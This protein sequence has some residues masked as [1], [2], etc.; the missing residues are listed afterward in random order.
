MAMPRVTTFLKRHTLAAGFVAVLT[1]LLVLLVMQ[2]V[3]LQR[4]ERATALAHR[5][6]LSNYLEAVGTEIQYFYRSNAERA[7][8]IPATYFTHGRLGEVAP[9]WE[10]KTGQGRRRL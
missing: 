6:T 3:W 9:L 10:K 4:L 2:F 5:A 7:L 8:N 1:P